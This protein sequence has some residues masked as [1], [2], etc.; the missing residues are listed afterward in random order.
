MP[1]VMRGAD[2]Q[3]Q[4]VRPQVDDAQAA[5]L[6]GWVSVEDKHPEYIAFLERELQR[7]DPFRE[8]DIH[9]ARVLEDLISLLIDK[10]VIRFTDFPAPAQKRLLDR[11]QM[12]KKSH[13][14]DIIDN[15]DSS[16]I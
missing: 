8:S 2:G 7:Q 9:L 5:K 6:E 10:Q 14:F 11:Q 13:I 15:G 3:I 16:P 1:Y 12:R 4:A